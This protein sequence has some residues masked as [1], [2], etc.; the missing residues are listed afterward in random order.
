L[1]GFVV[2]T[3][4]MFSLVLFSLLAASSA[5]VIPV[6]FANDNPSFKK[7]DPSLKKADL[8]FLQA[9]SSSDKKTLS[10]TLDQDF[11]WTDSVGK[12]YTRDEVL[13]NTPSSPANSISSEI[14]QRLYGQVGLILATSGKTHAARFWV[15][16]SDG[17]HLLIYHEATLAEEARSGAPRP[18]VCENP[19]KTLPYEPKNDA[20]RGIITS[21]QA[22]ETAVTNHD[23]QTWAQHIADEFLL[24]NSNNDHP[25]TKAD[26]IAILDKQKQTGTSSAPIPLVSAQMFDFGDTVIMAAKHQRDIDK[27][28]RVSRIWIKRDG[29]WL[30]AFSEQTIVQ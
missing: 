6:A 24:I 11:S 5:Q 12:T 22:L 16:R 20:E 14:Q 17:W 15:K 19:C 10:S 13:Q 26:R 2:I 3:R 8:A 23:S 21:W 30:M 18:K 29:Q 7:D 28:V 25:F 4:K 1:E 27:P 9:V